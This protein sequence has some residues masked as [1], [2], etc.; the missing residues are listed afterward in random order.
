MRYVHTADRHDRLPEDSNLLSLTSGKSALIRSI[1]RDCPTF[2]VVEAG[3]KWAVG[4]VL[5]YFQ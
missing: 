2:W 3:V 4:W 1:M 5:S